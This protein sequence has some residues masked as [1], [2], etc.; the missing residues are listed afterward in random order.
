MDS[1]IFLVTCKI[2]II[3]MVNFLIFHMD[4]F[5]FVSCLYNEQKKVRLQE[6]PQGH[7]KKTRNVRHLENFT[8]PT[9]GIFHFST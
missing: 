4:F 2:P 6:V 9:H 1:K 3:S 7:V 5:V 8:F